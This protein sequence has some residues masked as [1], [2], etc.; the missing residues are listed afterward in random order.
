M[1]QVTVDWFHL[2][3]VMAIRRWQWWRWWRWW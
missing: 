1:L 3:T 2:A